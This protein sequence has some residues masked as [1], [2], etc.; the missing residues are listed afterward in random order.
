[1]HVAV[2]LDAA[3]PELKGGEQ[4]PASREDSL[5]L[6]LAL[7]GV[8]LAGAVASPAGGLLHRRFTLTLPALAARAVCF[9]WHSSVGSPRLAVSQ[10]LAL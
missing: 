4:P 10:H 7:G 6:G 5:L 2:H 8:C 3:Y 9:L 1:M